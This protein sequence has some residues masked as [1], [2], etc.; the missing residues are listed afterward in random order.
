VIDFSIC[1][2]SRGPALGLWATVCACEAI[3]G[4][5]NLEYC[6]TIPWMTEPRRVMQDY[7]VKFYIADNFNPPEGR[8]FA[9][10]IATGKR[11]VFMDDHVIPTGDWFRQVAEL[12]KDVLHGPYK[13][14]IGTAPTYYHFYGQASMVEGDY[15]RTAL[16]DT[17][18][19]CGSAGHSNF[20]VRRDVF[21]RVGGYWSD[22][23][24]FGGEEASFD[25]NMWANGYEVWMNPKML[26]YHFSARAE[27]RGYQK[28]I[29]K[30]NYAM[31]L[32]KLKD[33]LPRLK[34]KFD[35]EGI[36][37]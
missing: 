2:P 24:D 9:A 37:Y 30:W 5:F 10:S 17:A 7:G 3:K 29:N 4:D 8:N 16:S 31:S 35:A 26:C 12:D 14:S 33:H 21:V 11:L 1:I 6:V 20:A 28:T 32:E 23:R 15:S 22:Y 19:R 18:Y 27:Q 25:L 13:T 34:A 36:P